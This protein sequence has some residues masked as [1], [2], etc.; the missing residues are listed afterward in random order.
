MLKET[1]S[2]N[3]TVLR[4]YFIINFYLENIYSTKVVATEVVNQIP[5]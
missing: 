5:L 3:I 1:F 4:Q 2:W